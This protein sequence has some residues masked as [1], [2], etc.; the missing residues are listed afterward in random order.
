[1][2]RN[3]SP[4][5]SSTGLEP[6]TETIWPLTS[7][8]TRFADPMKAAASFAVAYVGFTDPFV[9]MPRAGS[10]DHVA[11]SLRST[12]LG[13]VT[14]VVLQRLTNAGT[15]WVVGAKSKDIQVTWPTSRALVRSPVTLRGRST[16]F[17]A[18]VNV[19]IRDDRSLRPLVSTTVRG[20]SMGVMGPF[21]QSVSFA[22]ART[23]DGAVVFRIRSAKDGRVVEATVVPIRFQN[24]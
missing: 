22:S 2:T 3:R 18:V 8:T 21:A 4:N 23:R 14:T 16:A 9:S 1:M 24:R 6:T 13:P 20:G 5:P 11:V 15:W 19:T 12:S 7:S 10:K 17:E